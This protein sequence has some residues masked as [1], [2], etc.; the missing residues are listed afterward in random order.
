MSHAGPDCLY[1]ALHDRVARGWLRALSPRAL[2]I[3]LA[4]LDHVD[5]RQHTAWPGQD[6]L[7]TIIGKSTWSVRQ[8]IRELET[9]GLWIVKRGAIG[10]TRRRNLYCVPAHV[11]DS[12]ARQ[13]ARPAD[14]DRIASLR[15][16]NEED[17]PLHYKRAD[18]E[19]HS[20]G[21]AEDHP[22]GNAEDH[23]LM[24]Y[25]LEPR[26]EQRS[27]ASRS[28]TP[29]PNGPSAPTTGRLSPEELRRNRERVAQMVGQIGRPMP[30]WPQPRQGRTRG[31]A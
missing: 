17:G 29:N 22:R 5:W 9:A 26:S 23:P 15:R 24:N 6:R 4:L 2:R 25:V 21:D 18:A 14:P 11:P 20:R 27:T 7:A 31:T 1:R 10:K 28:P 19:D 13:R 16:R 3:D 8:A 30:A 12:P